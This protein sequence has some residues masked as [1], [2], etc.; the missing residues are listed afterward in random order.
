MSLHSSSSPVLPLLVLSLLLLSPRGT[1]AGRCPPA[2]QALTAITK[3]DSTGLYTIP[4]K[5]GAP[6][7]LDLAGPLVWSPC[8]SPH[9]TV[10]CKSSVCTVANRN[11]PASCAS[12]AN[13]GQ[14]GSADPNCACTAYAYNPASGQCAGGDLFSVPLSANATDGNN[15]LFP[16]TFS[17]YSACAPDGLLESLPSGAAGVAGLSRQPLSLPSQ[18]ASRLKVAKEFALCL[19][20]SGQTGAA[21]F[22][23]GAFVI[24]AAP[25]PIDFAGEIRQ[26]PL[27]ILKNPKNGAYYFGVRGIAVNQEHLNLPA[28]AFDLDRRQGTGGVVFS[29]AT[30][31]T[32]LRSDIYSAVMNAFDAVTRGIPRRKPFPPFQL[33]YDVSG[34]PTT[35]VGPAVPNIDLMLD[36]GRNWTLPGDSLLVQFGGGTAC[37]AFDSMGNEQSAAFYSPAVIFGAHQMENNLLLFDLEK[38]TFGSSG[39]LLGRSTTCGNFN[40]AMGSS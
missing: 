2:V 14:P 6:L 5:N 27:P 1:L 17:A 34:V 28:G 3:D 7:V 39:L 29:T 35:R 11:R 21:I 25:Q 24:Q 9:R 31:F 30:R 33:C 15:P 18:V 10:P 4:V 19:P 26:N 20:G 12:S 16:V 8:Q 22:G 36:G 23:G 38:G 32:T 13:G 37:F 40:F